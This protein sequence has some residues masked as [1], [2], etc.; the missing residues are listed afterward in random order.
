VV[1]IVALHGM[2][3]DSQEFLR[4]YRDVHTPIVQRIPGVK[5]IRFGQVIRTAN[6]GPAPYFLVSDTYFDSMEDLESALESDEMQEALEDVPNFASGG[7]TIMF[8]ESEDHA[9]ET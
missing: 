1:R 4:Y 8:C 2:P 9:P 5:N 6:G 3:D 7:V